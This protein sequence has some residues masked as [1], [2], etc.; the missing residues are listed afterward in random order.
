MTQDN[1]K[2]SL[3]QG[4]VR[5]GDADANLAHFSELL[6]LVPTDCQ[7]VVLPEMFS[8]G[9]SMN[10]ADNAEE[11]NGKTVS[12]I[13]ETAIQYGYAILAGVMIK[14]NDGYYNRAIFVYPDGSY[15]YY[16]KRH[17]FSYGKENEYY[18]AGDKRV[19]ISF[20][21]WR[22]RLQI[23][24]DLRFPVWSRNQN[25]YDILAYIASWPDARQT[26][27]NI[28][29]VARA[30]ENQCYVLASNRVGN[31]SSGN[32]AGESRIIDPKGIAI[33]TSE[34]YKEQLVTGTLSLSELKRFRE[35]FNVAADAD[36]FTTD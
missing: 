23:C 33:A 3:I 24:Y 35:K 14:E 7:L 21:G 9:F 1:L 19:I 8:T 36:N 27:W 28:L 4:D 25:D 22:I 30:I 31:D 12:W 2:V 26:V 6:K 17:L 32:Y 20:L 13:R 5:L 10:T 15:K 29:P 16:D 18:N 11:M 34:P